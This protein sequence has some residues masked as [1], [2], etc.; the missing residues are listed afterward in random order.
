MSEPDAPEDDAPVPAGGNLE[1]LVGLDWSS[2]TDDWDKQ[3]NLRWG[4]LALLLAYPPVG[5]S[6]SNLQETVGKLTKWVWDGKHSR[7]RAVGSDE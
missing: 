2:P 4:V 7:P 5:L 3:H 1:D 6:A